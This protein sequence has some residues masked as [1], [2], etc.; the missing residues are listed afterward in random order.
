MGTS[1][2]LAGCGG[3]TKVAATT[4]TTLGPLTLPVSLSAAESFFET[5]GGGG[6]TKDAL[7]SSMLFSFDGM[8]QDND[9]CP[10][11]ISGPG[12]ATAVSLINIHCATAGP[13]NTTFPQAVALFVAAVQRFAPAGVSWTQDAMRANISVSRKQTFGNAVLEVDIAPAKETA[14]LT[15][16]ASGFG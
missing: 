15:I 4:T 14:D 3:S 16:A 10:T 12:G 6:W 7:S 2:A 8:A 13:P 1:L 11:M 5:Q 9:T